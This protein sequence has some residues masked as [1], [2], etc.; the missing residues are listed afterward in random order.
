[1]NQS[2]EQLHIKVYAILA[3]NQADGPAQQAN[4]KGASERML[5]SLYHQLDYNNLVQLFDQN[6]H[7]ITLKTNKCGVGMK[8]RWLHNADLLKMQQL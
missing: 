1:M 3:P 8:L 7:L 4:P 6:E 5:V 2:T